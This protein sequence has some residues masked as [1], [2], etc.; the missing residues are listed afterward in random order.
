LAEEKWNFTK[1]GED[2]WLPEIL[3]AVPRQTGS[4]QRGNC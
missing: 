3:I 4:E 2:K 1:N